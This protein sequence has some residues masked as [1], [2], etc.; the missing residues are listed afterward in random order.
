MDGFSF[1]HIVFALEDGG[2]KTY[3]AAPVIMAFLLLNRPGM[4]VGLCEMKVWM[5][6]L[7]SVMLIC[8][9]QMN[10]FGMLLK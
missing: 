7:G 6:M 10:D 4:L 9:H 8:A 2:N 1:I 3:L 5:G